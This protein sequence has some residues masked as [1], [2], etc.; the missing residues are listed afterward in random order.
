MTELFCTMALF[1]VT[2]TTPDMSA[3]ELFQL[4]TILLAE[5]DLRIINEVNHM[6][7]RILLETVTI[8]HMIS[9]NGVPMVCLLL[10]PV[11]S[12]ATSDT[13][14]LSVLPISRS[15]PLIVTIVPPAAGPYDGLTEYT[16]G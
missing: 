14:V 15:S 10:L 1:T 13:V 12:V 4:H 16:L 8:A 3:V 11:V 9:Q 6:H 2:R 7:L 5:I